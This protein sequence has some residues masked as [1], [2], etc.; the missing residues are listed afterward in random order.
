MVLLGLHLQQ[1]ADKVV[2]EALGEA[3]HLHTSL[4]VYDLQGFFGSDRCQSK[5]DSQEI[6]FTPMCQGWTS[7][8]A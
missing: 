4:T 2:D 5:E 6:V 7:Y 8:G 1:A 3:L